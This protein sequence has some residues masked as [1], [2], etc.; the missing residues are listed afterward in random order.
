MRFV[1]HPDLHDRRRDDRLA[2]SP[3]DLALHRPAPARHG[4]R[5]GRRGHARERLG[6]RASDGTAVVQPGAHGSRQDGG[7]SADAGLLRSCAS[8]APGFAGRTGEQAAL[9]KRVSASLHR[10]QL[11]H[12]TTTAVRRGLTADRS[13]V[14]D[15][16]V[17][18]VLLQRR[19]LID[20]LDRS[21]ADRSGGAPGQ[22][23]ARTRAAPASAGGRTPPRAHRPRNGRRWRPGAR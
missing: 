2:V 1:P 3:G 16:D 21:L 15:Q 12:E 18:N 4:T 5:D 22:R 23:S 13:F 8:A 20:N 19:S 14:G 9:P 7:S 10:G 6:R 11:H 17:A